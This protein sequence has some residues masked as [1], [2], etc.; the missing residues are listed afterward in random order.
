[1]EKSPTLSKSKSII[2]NWGS[3]LVILHPSTPTIERI[4]WK[5]LSQPKWWWTIEMG[6]REK[7]I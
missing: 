6:K 4:A 2:E 1:M 3:P 7:G 5:E